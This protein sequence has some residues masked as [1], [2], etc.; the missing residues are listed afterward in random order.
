MIKR[1]ARS[2]VVAILGWQVRRLRRKFDIKVVAVAGSIGKTSTKFA[3]AQVLDQR[4]KVRFQEGNYNDLV[5]V[6]LVFFGQSMPGL[7]N[8]LAWLMVFLRNE[9]QIRRNFPY[10]VVVVEVGTDGP[11]QMTAFERYLHAD[12]AVLTS[13]APEH[14]EFFT[15]L[16]A[17]AV[18]ELTIQDYADLVFVNADLTDERYIEQVEQA[19]TYALHEPA[20]YKVSNFAFQPDGVK[21]ET[22]KKG[23]KFISATHSG[24][25]EPHLYSLA[26]AI[27]VADRLGMSDEEI[28]AGLE[29]VQPVSGRMQR[30]D[31]IN[32]STIIDDSYN[33]SPEAAKAALETLY[34]IDAPQKVALMGNM[35]ELGDYSK[36]AHIEVG[37]F[38]DPKQLDEVLTLGPDANEYLAIAAANAGCKV[39]KFETPYD[40]GKHLAEIIT[41][42]AV[43]LVKG[44]Q[45][46]VYA[47]EA[48]KEILADAR[49]VSKLVRQ[50]PSWLKKKAQN[51]N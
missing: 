47:E 43:V 42:G 49:D 3:I 33:S 32:G 30:L 26:A 51:F 48:I 18:E 4:F 37:S 2:L 39:T 24:I 19:E 28:V 27:S 36:Q 40:A 21:F 14:M 6:P 10:D 25:S 34:R 11:G 35:N 1:F 22:Q 29:H 16:D 41:D 45:N 13:I 46:R 12:V 15:D 44:S 8:P 38:C 17:V 50:S 23:K 20:T 9:L 31:G 7:L 5:S